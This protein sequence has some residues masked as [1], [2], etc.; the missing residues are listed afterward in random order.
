MDRCKKR[1]SE[2]GSESLE[3]TISELPNAQQ[4]AVRMCFAASKVT[5]P[6][7]QRYTLAWIYEC[8]LIRI[9]GR[10]TYD[11]LRKHKLLP[12]PS[13]VTLNKYIRKMNGCYGFQKSTFELLKKKSSS[14]KPQERRGMYTLGIYD[15]WFL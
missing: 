6:K 8:L 11:H 1:C 7:N 13:N 9:K 4:E 10:S 3:H 5:N 2:L 12:L 15:S 14:I